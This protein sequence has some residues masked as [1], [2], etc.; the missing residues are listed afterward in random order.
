MKPSNSFVF[1]PVKHAYTLDGVAMTGVTTI[2]QVVGD[3]SALI[4]WSANMAVDFLETVYKTDGVI[5]N[6]FFKEA[7][8]AHRRK[9]EEAGQKGTDVHFEVEKLVT[10]VI[11]AFGGIM[12]PDTKSEIPQVQHFIDWAVKN[13][14][15]F[16]E[17]EKQ[18]Y[19]KTYF[20]AGTLDFICEID[21]KV[22]V[23]DL[24][25]SKGIYGRSF[26][27]QCGA[28]RLC[29]EE[30]GYDRAFEGSI[31]VRIGKDGRFDEEK[32]VVCSLHYEEDKRY[33]LAALE[34]YRQ[35]NMFEKLNYQSNKKTIRI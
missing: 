31:I 19:S 9:K 34:V 28:Y 4:N 11:G 18:V 33:F 20:F 5:S 17:S 24:K 14:V 23:G 21:G 2:L 7:R 26:F 25:T 13:K 8:T 1:D 10:G 30:Q 22:Y 12:D 27:A 32:D 3:K 35:E 15:R 16:L 29:L 6:T